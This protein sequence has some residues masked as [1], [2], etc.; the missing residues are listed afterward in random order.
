MPAV[1]APCW[2]VPTVEAVIQL[3]ACVSRS[4]IPCWVLTCFIQGCWAQFTWDYIY[5]TFPQTE[6][7]VKCEQTTFP[8]SLSPPFHELKLWLN[9][10]NLPSLRDYHSTNTNVGKMWTDNFPPLTDSIFPQTQTLVKCE[11]TEPSMTPW[12]TNTMTPVLCA[13]LCCCEVLWLPNTPASLSPQHFPQTHY[14]EVLLFIHLQCFDHDPEDAVVC[15]LKSRLVT[16][17]SL[18]ILAIDVYGWCCV[19]E[20]LF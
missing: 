5:I 2:S 4:T 20:D 15:V 7:L 19:P 6:T 11:Q 8:L 14:L 16:K 3:A 12:L 17:L 9:V 1:S 13:L 18:H 10:N